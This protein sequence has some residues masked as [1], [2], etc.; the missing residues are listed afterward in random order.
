MTI[1]NA[2]TKKFGNLLKASR[3]PQPALLYKIILKSWIR[4]DIHFLSTLRQKR[5]PD[6]LKMHM[7]LPAFMMIL[8]FN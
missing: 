3:I 4:D 8:F 6:K 1:L 5:D 2:C 7:M